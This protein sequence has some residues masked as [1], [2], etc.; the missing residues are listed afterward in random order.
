MLY[1]IPILVPQSTT[2][3]LFYL[4]IRF[5]HLQ[6]MPRL[7]LVISPM[8]N[9]L[10]LPPSSVLGCCVLL[11]LR[12]L[13]LSVS[14]VLVPVFLYDETYNLLRLSSYQSTAVYSVL[15]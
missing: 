15:Q 14:V 8:D 11:L 2:L 13:P 3:L 9:V 6:S 12:I 10:L 1:D 7:L 4:L 5:P